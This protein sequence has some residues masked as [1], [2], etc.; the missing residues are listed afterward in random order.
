MSIDYKIGLSR[1]RLF[2]FQNCVSFVGEY[3]EEFSEKELSKAIKMLG[4]KKP[5]ITSQI[6][7]AENAEAF[8]QLERVEPG[9]HF[10]EADVSAFVDEYKSNGLNFTEKLFE[11]FV[12][13]KNTLVIFSHTVVSDAKSL[14]IL[15]KELLSYYNK[16]SVSVEPDE[17]KLFSTD[18]EIPSEAESFV[19]DRVT[20]VLN[21]DWLMKPKSFSFDDYKAA[22]QK[23]LE[24]KSETKCKD[25]YFDDELTALLNERSQDLKIDLS[26]LV[27]FAL[28]KVFSENTKS[29]KK[30]HKMNAQLD[31]RPFFV[32]SEAYSVG[33][34]NGTV[35]LELP[36]K[37]SDLTE[38][39][40]AFHKVYYKKF[41]ECFNA[42]YNELFL[43]KLE[44][45]FLDSAFI[46]KAK[47]Y[48]S[49][50]T[51]KL[52]TL[53]GCEQKF[54]LSFA[55]YNLS[56]KSWE[57]LSTFNHILVNEPHKS[58]ESVSATLILSRK[59]M[60]H[61][62]WESEAYNDEKITEI[63]ESFVSVLKQL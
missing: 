58:N 63:L 3:S 10:I 5:I 11:F 9:I 27:A 61:L 57:K 33:A 49:K 16:E 52:A 46:Y 44:P 31:R 37:L 1:C 14:L 56:Q 51:K 23:F 35:S 24:E 25:F 13:N 60:L 34:F 29:D 32:N 47:Q 62:E 42:F 21:N 59:N 18:A 15:A 26:S 54:L 50:P 41:S 19:A 36:K 38:Q 8:L 4:V 28:L 43:S 45:S 30:I 40:K 53:Y 6:E 20:E 12:L 17:I 22:K 55:S 2:D 39:V 7:L 48:K